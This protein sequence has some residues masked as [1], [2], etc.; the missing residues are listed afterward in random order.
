MQ[1]MVG[2]VL[3]QELLL[4]SRRNRLHVFR[5]IY[6]AWL[7]VQ[8]LYFGLEALSQSQLLA[9]GA[10][11]AAGTGGGAEVRVLMLTA[12]RGRFTE[13]FVAQQMLLLVLVTPAFVA[14]AIT[15]EKRRGTLQYLLTTDLDTRHI[16]LGKLLGR[17]AQVALV[18]LAG[19]PLFALLAGFGGVA[20]LTLVFVAAVLIAPLFALTSATLLASV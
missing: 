20:P 19:L 9:G 14:G 5:W 8:L 18:A 11:Y 6:A 16:I 4:G 15:D 13:T 17:M 2:P 7:L 10:P 1:P 12:V 3:H